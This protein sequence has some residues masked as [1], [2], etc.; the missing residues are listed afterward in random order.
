MTPEAATWLASSQIR[1]RI[2]ELFD[3]QRLKEAA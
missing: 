2:A 3:V 1:D